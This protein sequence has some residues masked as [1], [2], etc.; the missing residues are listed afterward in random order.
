MA[1]EEAHRGHG[2]CLPDCPVWVALKGT[3]HSLELVKTTV[4]TNLSGLAQALNAQSQQNEARLSRLELVSKPVSHEGSGDCCPPSCAMPHRM[5]DTERQ[6]AVQGKIMVELQAFMED[7]GDLLSI[8]LGDTHSLGRHLEG[9]K[10]Q[11]RNMGPKLDPI[12]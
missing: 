2:C 3:D 10:V 6:V 12:S 5:Y 1:G 9:L 8:N 4:A 7:I 11:V